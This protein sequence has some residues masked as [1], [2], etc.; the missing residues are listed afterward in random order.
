MMSPYLHFLVSVG[1]W[2]QTHDVIVIS[3]SVGVVL[4][5][6]LARFLVWRSSVHNRRPWP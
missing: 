2:A 6:S 4:V 1:L 5:L 3:V